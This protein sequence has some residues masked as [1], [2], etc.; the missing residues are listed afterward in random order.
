MKRILTRLATIFFIPLSA[1]ADT[2][3]LPGQV[4]AFFGR[5]LDQ[6]VNPL[7]TLGFA[8]AVLYLAWA[9][10]QYTMGG[11]KLEKDKLK[12]SLIYG[13]LGV[14]IMATVFGILKFLAVSVGA[15]ETIVTQNV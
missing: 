8:V 10:L 6:I 4:R 2:A 15:P 3:V 12:S 7:I 1:F 5:V 13:V 9:V 14:A 11:D